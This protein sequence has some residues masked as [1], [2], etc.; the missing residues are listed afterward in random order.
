MPMIRRIDP[1]TTMS[2]ATVH[3]GVIYF[4]GHVAPGADM[5]EQ[6]TKLLT[7]YEELLLE[8][9]SDK[10]HILFATIYVTDMAL[11]GEFNA[12]WDKWLHPGCA[13]AR[14]CVEAGLGGGGFL[15][16]VAITAALLEA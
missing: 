10:N 16:E 13:P 4:C 6:A 5:T 14:V 3:N 8:N 7:R 12:V 1:D 2:R 15:V 11:K 9:G